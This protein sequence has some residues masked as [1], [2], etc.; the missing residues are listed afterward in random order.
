VQETKFC[1]PREA[2]LHPL[3]RHA[4]RLISRGLREA[5]AALN[6]QR[7]PVH[8]PVAAH[9]LPDAHHLAVTA[10]DPAL[11]T[12]EEQRLAVQLTA[13]RAASIRD[14]PHAAL[15][16]ILGE[17]A[18]MQQMGGGEALVGQL[19]QIAGE[20]EEIPSPVTLQVIPFTAS[21]HPAI[22]AGPVSIIRFRG[23][24][25]IG[26]ICQGWN[27]PGASVVRQAQL[28][29]AVRR[30]EALRAAALSPDESQQLIRKAIDTLQ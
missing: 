7:Q 17:A 1:A 29:A 11:E 26:A 4:E 25:G 27:T 23:V 22:G 30:F 21:M 12:D 24:A 14:R 6:A 13:R 5:T 16:V 19:Q 9:R 3:R 15:T 18:L 28:T 8:G 2:T 20:A 10:A